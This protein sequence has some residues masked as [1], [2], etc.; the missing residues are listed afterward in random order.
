MLEAAQQLI[1]AA[2]TRVHVNR[3]RE[4]V[5]NGVPMISK[6]RRRGAG[7]VIAG[8]N[9]FLALA[10]SGV[11]MF[12]RAPAWID[13][14][15]YCT[16][17]LYPQAAPTRAISRRAV[18]LARIPGTSLRQSL[19]EGQPLSSA[20]HSAAMEIFRAH[21]L[22]CPRYRSKWSHGDLHLDNVL[23]DATTGRAF[24]VDFDTR[25]V[26]NLS[27]EWRHADDLLVL[28]LDLLATDGENW[29]ALADAFLEAY[30]DA[31]VLGE[32]ERRLT[33]PRGFSKILFHTRTGGRPTQQIETRLRE[34]RPMIRI[35]AERIANTGR[36]V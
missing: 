15:R 18:G 33:V 27:S 12:V 11:R 13:W 25:H 2:M 7:M 1:A 8:G 20:L 17:L 29:R 31:R 22:E 35:A 5:L 9:L 14:E 10:H 26:G 24:L 32:L 3:S 34:L 4:T 28:L 16:Q 21:Q 23:Y 6:T 19:C 36:L 30:P